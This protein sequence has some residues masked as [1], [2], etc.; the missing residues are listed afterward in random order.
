LVTFA[1]LQT[2]LWN[3]D[4]ILL[5]LGNLFMAMGFYFL[6]PTLP[7]YVVNVLGARKHEVGYVLAAYA[8]SALIIRPFT[9]M[10]V[11]RFG[12]KW[13]Y[14]FSFLIFSLMLAAYPLMATFM[15]LLALRFIHG[16]AWGIT[17][18]AGSTAVV[19]IIPPTKR[20]RGIGY[21]G[22]SFTIS[23]AL[24]PLFALWILK[25][26]SF[27]WMFV[28]A[29]LVALLGFLMITFVSFPWLDLKR[30]KVRLTM[31]RLIEFSSLPMAITYMFFGMAYGGIISYITLYDQELHLNLSGPF[32][33]LIS[34]GVFLSR[35]FAGRIFDNRGPFRLIITGF[36]LAMT[37]LAV[38]GLYPR[39]TGFLTSAFLIGVGSGILM[40][41]LQAMVNNV[42][43][44]DR[45]GIANA[46]LITAF[47]L[48]IG[49]G[50]V[51]L[52]LLAEWTG[53]SRMF[54]LCILILAVALAYYILYVDRFY[55]RKRIRMIE[56]TGFY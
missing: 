36:L 53:L 3:K 54:Q 35:I 7:V 51:L 20:G 19:D 16:F 15:M 24:G 8:I 40:P 32:F 2:K 27:S 52:G 56:M 6:I 21:F 22:I 41:T 26:T 29:S 5:A 4:F 45:R 34:C 55:H 47:D 13:I 50:S 12:R 42:V 23:M 17:T 48:G 38:L 14:I 33:I 25:M 46:T 30:T 44:V 10:A 31:D 43:M 9:G 11:D 28:I 39:A 49:S 18:T 37:G 1:R